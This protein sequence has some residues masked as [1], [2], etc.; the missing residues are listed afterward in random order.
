MSSENLGN[1]IQSLSVL[2]VEKNH[3]EVDLQ[4]IDSK[5]TKLEREIMNA[6]D[7]DGIEESASAVGK[8]SVKTHIY[9][10]I[11]VWSS[12]EDY[13]FEERVMLLEHRVAVKTY[14]ELL[15]LRRVVPG[16][17]PSPVR[18][19]TYRPL[20]NDDRHDRTAEPATG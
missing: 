18:K 4:Q 5:I 3:I 2:V 9:P 10:K 14:R 1:L 17:V 6:L 13:I 20:N 7:A 11:E 16:V 15:D 19:L 12:L 8:V